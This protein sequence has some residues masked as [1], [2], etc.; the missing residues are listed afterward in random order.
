M[1]ARNIEIK[2]Q[3][4]DPQSLIDRWRAL[5]TDPPQVLNQEDTFFI[6][7]SGRLK[8]RDVNGN[9]EL[10]FY[11]RADED[12]PKLSAYTVLDMNEQAALKELL[13]AALGT[14]GVVKKKRILMLVDQTRI[15]LDA[16]E[17]LGNFLELETVL[18][19]EQS[20]DQGVRIQNDLIFQL[21]IDH[22]PRIKGAYLDLLGNPRT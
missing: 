6:V 18:R 19:P 13:V 12:G 21:G 15:H 3:I 22:F 9:Q 5:A 10:I 11:Q 2:M 14:L 1:S 17:G 8:W 20:L 4:D 7:P 16:V